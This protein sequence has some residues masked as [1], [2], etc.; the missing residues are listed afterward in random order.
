LKRISIEIISSRELAH[1]ILNFIIFPHSMF[2]LWVLSLSL[3]L[4]E[5]DL[6]AVI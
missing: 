5:L 1:S 2:K 3:L 6:L 4:L